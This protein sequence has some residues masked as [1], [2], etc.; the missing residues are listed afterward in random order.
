[1][2]WCGVQQ[3]RSELLNYFLAV[4]AQTTGPSRP[5]LATDRRRGDSPSLPEPRSSL[6]LLQRLCAVFVVLWR[7]AVRTVA[8]ACLG[9]A[10]CDEC[11]VAAP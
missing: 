1:V 5:S 8:A 6:L 3:G 10:R 2:R 11:R 7:V 4:N 9:L